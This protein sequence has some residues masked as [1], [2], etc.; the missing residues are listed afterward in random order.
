MLNSDRTYNSV[1]QYFH[2][3]EHDPEGLTHCRGPENNPYRIV[4]YKGDHIINV[5]A[6]RGHGKGNIPQWFKFTERSGSGWKLSSG[7]KVDN[8]TLTKEDKTKLYF[9]INDSA[10][11]RILKAMNSTKE[12]EN[13]LDS[14]KVLKPIPVA[15]PKV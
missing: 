3:Y 10:P 1:L 2:N 11:M 14:L 4:H 12:H 9:N 7:E 15:K 5:K 8:S 13:A 6:A